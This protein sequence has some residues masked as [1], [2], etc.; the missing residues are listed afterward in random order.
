MCQEYFATK[1]DELASKEWLDKGLSLMNAEKYPEALNTLGDYQQ[2]LLDE[3]RQ[4]WTRTSS[5]SGMTPTSRDLW[6]DPHMNAP[7]RTSC[8]L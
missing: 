2:A 1:C 6:S 3:E 5:P 7:P 8:S 4:K